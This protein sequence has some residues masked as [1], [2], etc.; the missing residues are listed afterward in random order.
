MIVSLF[1]A[2]IV[3]LTIVTLMVTK[4]EAKSIEM[5]LS[6]YDGLLMREKPDDDAKVLIT[7]SFADKVKVKKRNLG[8]DKS[9]A[10]I[11]VNKQKGYVHMDY[12]QLTDPMEDME[13]LGNWHT[14]AYTHT[15]N[16]CANGNYPTAGYTVA[17]NSL[18]FGTK[19]FIKDI[20]VRVVEDRGP[21]WLG[22][23]WAD[24]FMD[25]YDACIGF[26]EQYLDVYLI[27]EEG[28]E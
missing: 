3:W 1:V 9:W 11:K 23:E 27:K 22:S 19:V 26:G 20:G 17:C 7:L 18:D 8:D 13:Y 12:L 21:G 4:A 24:I 15:G 2:L 28:E 10:K 5:Y 16:V 6:S 25:S 14:T